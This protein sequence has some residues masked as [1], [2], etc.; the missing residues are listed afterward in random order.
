MVISR[1]QAAEYRERLAFGAEVAAA[2]ANGSNG[3]SGNAF[4]RGAEA[5]EGEKEPAAA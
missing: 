2:A 3:S 1:M 4:E 5:L